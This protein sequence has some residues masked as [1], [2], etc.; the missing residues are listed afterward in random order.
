MARPPN[1]R[2]A[3]VRVYGRRLPPG[4]H[5][6][7]VNRA[8]RVQRVPDRVEQYLSV[9]IT[10]RSEVQ[11]LPPLPRSSRSEARLPR[12]AVGPFGCLLAVR[13]RDG[14]RQGGMWCGGAAEIGIG[15]V[16]W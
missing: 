12:T 13:W 3:S 16:G 14:T 9:L 10:Q 11:I 5:A 15:G 7:E 1:H 6:D 4:T 8:A 2:T